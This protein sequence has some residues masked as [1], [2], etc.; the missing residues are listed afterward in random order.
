MKQINL[1]NWLST[2]AGTTLPQLLCLFTDEPLFSTQ[3]ADLYRQRLKQQTD[4]Q[5]HVIE[6]DRQFDPQEFLALFAEV[7]LFG[8]VSL[9]DLRI[10]Q[11]KLSKEAAEALGTVAGW[12][13]K[14]DTSHHLLVSGPKLNKTQEKSA[15]FAELLAS[16]TEVACRPVTADNL[17]GWISQ[18]ARRKGL[19]LDKDT[20]AWLAEKTEGNL[21]VAHQTVEK[22][23]LEQQGPVPIELVQGMV[24]NSARFNVFDLGAGLLAGD[25]RRVVRMLE[26]LEAEGEAATLVLWAMQEE[27]R[28]IRDTQQ[29]MRRG[30]SFSDAC[31][32]NRIWG[33]RQTHIAAALKRHNAA[34]LQKLT[35]WCYAAEKTIKGMKQGN[36]WTLLEI[37]GL[38]LA[39]VQLPESPPESWNT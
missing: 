21:L 9:V 3:A 39:G 12:I 24:A 37:I 27:I 7:S 25:T 38:G 17:P 34:G 28:A 30:M 10:S 11:P 6:V 23:A 16:G 26:G 4:C 15:G 31:R 35:S 32:Q 20:C 22:L 1:D 29:A 5:R 13:S 36:P 14:G 8:D 19:Q 2:P 33:V 18:T